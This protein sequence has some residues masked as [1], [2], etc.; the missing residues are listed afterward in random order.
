[1]VAKEC[2][3]VTDMKSDLITENNPI[4]VS[5]ICVL[6]L[7]MS[8]MR[9]QHSSLLFRMENRGVQKNPEQKIDVALELK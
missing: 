4:P 5:V 7:C 3:T 2:E 8:F 6:V 9:S 1:M